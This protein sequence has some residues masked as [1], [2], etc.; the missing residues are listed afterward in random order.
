MAMADS[1]PAVRARELGAAMRELREE[2]GFTVRAAGDR[3]D[4]QRTVPS[5]RSPARTY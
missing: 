3:V 4:L 2:A 1:D 5:W